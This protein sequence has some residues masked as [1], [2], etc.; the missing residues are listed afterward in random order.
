MSLKKRISGYRSRIITAVQIQFS[1]D[2]GKTWNEHEKGKWFS[3]GQLAAD[4]N[5]MQRKFEIS[6]PVN[7]NAFRVIID[8]AHTTGGPHVQGRF[9]LW[10][11]KNSEYKPKELEAMP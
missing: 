3:T 9:D 1:Q 8:K 5:S 4:S 6:P 7:G 10:V 2:D 11:V